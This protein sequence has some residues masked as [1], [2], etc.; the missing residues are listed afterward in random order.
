MIHNPPFTL[1]ATT[2]VALAGSLVMSLATVALAGGPPPGAGKPTAE[3][4]TPAAPATTAPAIPE[5]ETPEPE[6]PEP[7]TPAATP[8]QSQTTPSRFPLPLARVSPTEGTITVKLVN[9][10]N[11][12]INYQVVGDTQQRTLGEQSEIQ[13]KNLTAPINITYQR[14]DGGLLVV[15]AQA[16]ATPGLLQVS[17]GATEDLSLDTKSLN[18]QEDG[19]VF[20]Q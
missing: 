16:T 6:T 7:E 9:T 11:A 17:F 15:R 3:P 5:P 4:A 2:L 14:Q 20:A 18:I 1:K 8:A 19:R 13:L 10:T 12:L